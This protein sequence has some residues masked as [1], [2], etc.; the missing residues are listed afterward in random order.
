LL[1][2]ALGV[3]VVWDVKGK[4]WF[5]KWLSGFEWKLSC[6]TLK[7]R[8]ICFQR[9]VYPHLSLKMNQGWRITVTYFCFLGGFCFL[10]CV[11]VVFPGWG[12]F[13][14]KSS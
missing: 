11:R 13:A 9:R 5:G 8:K 6:G 14:D 3:W 7:R 10:F 1:A 2:F 4:F 12:I